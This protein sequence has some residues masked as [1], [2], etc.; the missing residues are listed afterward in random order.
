M[1]QPILF[2]QAIDYV[3]IYSNNDS[4]VRY[5]NS[6]QYTQVTPPEAANMN[7]I[8]RTLVQAEA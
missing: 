1:F 2:D 8:L 7:R 6:R 3:A 5:N 4:S